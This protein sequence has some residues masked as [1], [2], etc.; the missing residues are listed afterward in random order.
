MSDPFVSERVNAFADAA[1]LAGARVHYMKRFVRGS[2][3]LIVGSEGEVFVFAVDLE[4]VSE[5]RPQ[6]SLERERWLVWAGTSVRYVNSVA[7]MLDIL[8]DT[9][10]DP[11]PDPNPE[12]NPGTVDDFENGFGWSLLGEFDRTAYMSPARIDTTGGVESSGRPANV[13][14][15]TIST[16]DTNNRCELFCV[17]DTKMWREGDVVRWKFQSLFP[18]SFPSYPVNQ[19]VTFARVLANVNGLGCIEL[20]VKGENI[21]FRE[22]GDE[23]SVALQTTLDATGGYLWSRALVRERWFRW[24]VKVWVS[25]NPLVGGAEIYLDDV[26]VPV[27]TRK[28]FKTITD[29]SGTKRSRPYQGM[30]RHSSIT[31]DTVVRYTNF[32]WEI[33]RPTP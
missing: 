22:N 11:D 32:W 8:N 31:G 26:T 33:T 12:P 20:M 15:H 28:Y 18:T 17:D 13:M 7:T 14:T 10:P 9:E 30:R 29:T 19:Y 4:S 5:D 3:D 1:R 2:A 23:H 27:M 24:E 21:W 16:G 6:V 25:E